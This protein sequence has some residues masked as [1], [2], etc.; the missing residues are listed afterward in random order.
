MANLLNALQTDDLIIYGLMAVVGVILV[1]VIVSAIVRGVRRSR[2][3]KQ[4]A[5]TVAVVAD[6]IN[7]EEEPVAE[8]NQQTSGQTLTQNVCDIAQTNGSEQQGDATPEG[9][10]QQQPVMT[11]KKAVHVKERLVHVVYDRSFKARIMQADD[12][13]K[14]F[15]DILKNKLLSYKGVKSRFSWG[16]E[17]FRIGRKLYAMLVVKGKTLNLYLAMDPASLADTKFK[18]EDAS[19]SKK[20]SE[21]PTCY[22]VKNPLRSRYASELIEMLFDGIQ[23]SGA[24][25]TDYKLPYE[26][27]A[28]LVDMGLVK[29]KA[30][31]STENAR[32]VKADI[33]ELI[34]SKITVA[35]A[36]AI[37]PDEL[38]GAM[39]ERKGFER[40]YGDKKGIVNIDTI[41]ANF[42]EGEDVTLEALKDKGLVAKNIGYYKVL[43]RGTL[44]KKLN[45]YADDYS[46]AA[47]KMIVLTGG[48]AFLPEKQ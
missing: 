29:L 42:N 48:D 6:S 16:A 32:I 36:D 2:S 35:E 17:S 9:D 25:Y 19:D 41:S 20:Y 11:E 28:K 37:V 34:R 33:A 8:D 43:A 22:A 3:N 47:V 10:R 4:P 23:P 5:A 14:E 39:L 1:V 30:D 46:A 15:Y 24:S 38:V 44:D 7:V 13:L 12:Q 27:T 26:T 45:V 18:A 31:G 40:S 21:V